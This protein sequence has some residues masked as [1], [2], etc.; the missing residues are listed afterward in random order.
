MELGAE[1]Q[2]FPVGKKHWDLLCQQPL[3]M[4]SGQV[5]EGNLEEGAGVQMEAETRS[6]RRGAVVNESD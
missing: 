6:S 3:V 5:E 1:M 2:T 4:L